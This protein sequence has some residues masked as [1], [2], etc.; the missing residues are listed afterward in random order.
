MIAVD[1]SPRWRCEEARVAE[2]RLN[3]SSWS[4]RRSATNR[5]SFPNPWTEVHGYFIDRSAVTEASRISLILKANWNKSGS[6]A[7]KAQ[8]RRAMR[9]FP[10]SSS[11]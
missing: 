9:R 4:S 3:H 7:P 5:L 2:R 1:F 10:R 6:Q 8:R 11:L